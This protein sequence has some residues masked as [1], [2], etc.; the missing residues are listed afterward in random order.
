MNL[1]QRKIGESSPIELMSYLISKLNGSNWISDEL[2]MELYLQPIKCQ[3]QIF[4]ELVERGFDVNRIIRV[5]AFWVL[6]F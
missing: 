1:E 6:F 4:P 3:L 2:I 5:S